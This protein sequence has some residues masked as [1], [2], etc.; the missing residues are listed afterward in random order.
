MS[1]G[2][3]FQNTP[4]PCTPRRSLY[5]YGLKL[6]IIECRHSKTIVFGWEAE[7]FGEKLLVLSG[8]CY[9][10]CNSMEG[11]LL[12]YRTCT[13]LYFFYKGLHGIL[14]H[15]LWILNL[16]RSIGQQKGPWPFSFRT[17]QEVS[18]NDLW[19]TVY[20]S[21]FWLGSEK[22]TVWSRFQFSFQR[23]TDYFLFTPYPDTFSGSAI[24]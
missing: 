9:I 8:E 3:E 16:S 2:T 1:L 24:G 13:N 14:K 18:L 19:G 12:D 10:C 22:T 4:G 20:C 23:T 15:T 17:K 11:F 7:S 5:Q 6:F 21:R